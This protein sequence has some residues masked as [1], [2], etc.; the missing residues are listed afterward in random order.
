[1]Q[2]ETS[3]WLGASD[4]NAA[5]AM[6]SE[7]LTI[8]CRRGIAATMPVV[9]FPPSSCRQSIFGI[10]GVDLTI[11][12]TRQ[13][14]CGRPE[15]ARGRATQWATNHNNADWMYAKACSLGWARGTRVRISGFSQLARA[16]QRGVI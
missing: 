4:L 2:I 16:A 10:Y 15:S 14:N 8:D 13:I 6:R 12:R 5:K 9:P 3:T 1:M 7:N 11:A